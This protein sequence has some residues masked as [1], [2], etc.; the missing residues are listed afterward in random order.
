MF[1]FQG[2]Y[3]GQ[4]IIADYFFTLVSQ[5]WGLLIEV[6]DIACFFNK[7]CFTFAAGQPVP[8]L[9][10]FEVRFFLKDDRRDG[11]KWSQRYLV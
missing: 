11:P 3:P 4:F 1:A 8:E 5:V 6:V 10:R 7:Q 9:M 2:L